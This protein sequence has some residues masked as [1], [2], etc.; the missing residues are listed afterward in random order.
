VEFLGFIRPGDE[1]G[2]RNY[3]LIIPS[4]R[5]VDI[6][7]TR[8]TQYVEGTKTVITGGENGR[9]KR[10][11]ERLGRLYTGLARNANAYATIILGAKNNFGYAELQPHILAHE[12]AKSGKPV[13]VLTV[14]DSGGLERLVEDG[15]AMAR[16]FVHD[17]SLVKRERVSLDKLAIGVKCGLSDATSGISGNPSFGKASDLLISAGGTSIFSETVEVIG[18]E[19]DVAG[20]C[21]NKR[22]AERLLEMVREVE[23]AA[24]QTG[25]DIRTINPLP[26]NIEAG[27]S[28]LEEKSLGAIQKVGTMPIQGVLEYAT[29]PSGKGL[30]FMD[31]WMSSFS[32]PMS[33]AAA[34]S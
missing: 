23:E 7:A 16:S 5:L 24:K 3:V 25:E 20:R 4:T 2:V 34:G 10:D 19:Q 22:D 30:Y 1:A 9:H 11:R 29:R 33:L 18:A 27:I 26:S 31:G 15:I 32:L 12:I 13:E 8:I 28:T 6:A 21:V 17:A 14:E